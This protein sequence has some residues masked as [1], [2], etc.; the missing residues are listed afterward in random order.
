MRLETMRESGKKNLRNRTIA[1]FKRIRDGLTAADE[2]P[3]FMFLSLAK[4]Y[5]LM[6][7]PRRT[8]PLSASSVQSLII[9]LF[10]QFCAHG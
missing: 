6:K 4:N 3:V 2:V 5:C 8:V 1:A 9:W 10:L 7:M